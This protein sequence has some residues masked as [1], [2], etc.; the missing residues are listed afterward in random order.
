MAIAK[1]NTVANPG[2][3]STKAAA[4]EQVNQEGAVIAKAETLNIETEGKTAEELQETIQE[5][6]DLQADI[7]NEARNA[8]IV[9][10]LAAYLGVEDLEALTKAEVEKLLAE[11]EA[12][13]ANGIEVVEEVV[14]EGKTDKAFT[15]SNG[16]EYVFTEDAPAKFRYLGV[17]KTQE[18]WIA[19]GDS[20]E[21][22]IAGRLSFLTLKK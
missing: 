22:M 20:V 5:V 3:E 12:K 7:N 8:E 21:L 11:K 16:K 1:K 9:A 4:P 10:Y 17:L 14:L 2:A 6:E 18:E 13:I 15:A 19:D